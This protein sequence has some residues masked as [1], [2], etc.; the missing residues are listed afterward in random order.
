[1]MKKMKKI[2]K[3]EESN[4]ISRGCCWR[5]VKDSI[6]TDFSPALVLLSNNSR[7]LRDGL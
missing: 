4:Q 6:R 1:M 7:F 3:K 5:K 2:E